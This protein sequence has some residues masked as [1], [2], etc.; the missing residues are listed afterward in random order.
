LQIAFRHGLSHIG[1]LA[2]G[3]SVGLF[4]GAAVL[5]QAMLGRGRHAAV[6]SGWL[7][8][9]VGLG[10]G[11]IVSASPVTRATA[12]FLCGALASSLAF[13]VLVTADLRRWA[14]VAGRV[15]RHQH[16]SAPSWSRSV[17]ATC[18]LEAADGPVTPAAQ[19]IEAW[20]RPTVRL[21]LALGTSALIALVIWAR[22]PRHL[23]GRIDIVGYPTFA[24]YDYLPS[25][26]AYRLVV[27]VF[28]I[29]AIAL[30]LLLAWRGPLRRPSRIKPLPAIALTVDDE[31]DEP[32]FAAGRLLSLAAR[33]ALPAGVLALEASA[34]AHARQVG[35][36][37]VAYGLTYVLG[38]LVAAALSAGLLQRGPVRSFARRWARDVAAINGVLAGFVALIGL[39][40]ATRECSVFVSSDRTRHYYA[41]LPWWLGVP[42]ALGAAGWAVWRLR[43]GMAARLVE[44][45]V[46]KVAVGSVFVFIAISTIP[47][48]LGRFVGFDDAQ[49]LTGGWLLSRGLF[50]WR[51]M[52]FIHGLYPDVLTGSISAHLFGE[53][54]WAG[55]AGITAVLNPLA[56]VLLYLLAV[57]TCRRNTWLP[58]LAVLVVLSGITLGVQQRFILVPIAL[59]L[60]GETVRRQSARWCAVLALLLFALEILVPET[61]FVSIPILLALAAADFTHRNPGR[62]LRAAFRRTYWVLGTGLALAAVW[63]AFLAANDSLGS[64]IQYYLIFGPGH[65]ASGVIPPIQIKQSGWNYFGLGIALVLVTYA[66]VTYRLRTRKDWAPRQWVMVAAAGFAALYGEKALGRF[67]LGHLHESFTA[68]M[69][70]IVLQADAGLSWADRRIREAARSG[71]LREFRLQSPVRHPVTVCAF[72]V[73]L[74]VIPVFHTGPSIWSQVRTIPGRTHAVVAEEPSVAQLGYSLPGA[75]DPALVS[76]L[77]A[78]LNT[79]AGTTAPVFDMTNSPGYIYYLLNRIPA[80]KFVHVSMAVPASAQKTLIDGLKKSRPPVIVFD[81]RN[82]GLPAWDGISNQV[83]HYLVSRFVLRGWVPVLQTHSFLLMVRKDLIASLP[84]APDLTEPARTSSLYFSSGSC[85]WGNV[86]NFLT[87]KPAGRSL[88]IPVTPAGTVTRVSGWAADPVAKRPAK[89]IMLVVGGKVRAVVAPSIARID[90][91]RVIGVSF[92]GVGFS[93]V[94]RPAPP[95]AVIALALASDGKLHPIKGEPVDVL[96]PRSVRLPDGSEVAVGAPLPGKLESQTPERVGEAVLPADIDPSQFDLLTLRAAGRLGTAGLAITDAL[97]SGDGEQIRVN[98]LPASGDT[99]GVRVGSCLP[100]YGY[101]TRQLYVIR[102]GGAPITRIELSGVR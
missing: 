51:D 30:Y 78:A 19:P 81:S 13:A 48:A 17:K 31:P 92:I 67:D 7:I 14:A 8:G 87:S 15:A 46:L 99:L 50:P 88:T 75:V 85:D 94:L 12:G 86:P 39:W 28:P 10:L 80:S 60:F 89:S 58:I 83:R 53:T 66:V 62:P 90:V 2:L 70:L 100:W 59:V 6:C 95:D 27:Y 49:S 71:R 1:F 45:T 65:N 40:V 38:V 23:S 11:T 34:H 52:L 79:Y 26:L 72:V 3:I 42:L 98:A 4:L 21:V 74:L 68:T 20:W 54:R 25:F 37:G 56:W 61:L 63:A 57:W 101:S 47:G 16:P 91:A 102:A 93:A 84:P 5:A 69:P 96:V 55:T 36:H 33:L 76:D 64:F 22:E 41:W 24:N 44:T 73:C 43:R 29:L 18:S 32:D 35:R 82:I 97:P 9:L 77:K